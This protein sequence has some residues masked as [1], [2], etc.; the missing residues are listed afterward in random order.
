MCD[1]VGLMVE[2]IET[3]VYLCIFGSRDYNPKVSS[4]PNPPPFSPPPDPLP[5][6]TPAMQAIIVTAFLSRLYYPLDLVTTV[7]QSLWFIV[8][9]SECLLE[10]KHLSTCIW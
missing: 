5:C 6:L 2:S 1:F 4:R 10:R 7:Y 8:S 9:L 3:T